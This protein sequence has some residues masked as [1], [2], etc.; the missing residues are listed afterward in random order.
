MKRKFVKVQMN[1]KKFMFLLDTGSDVTLINEQ[2]WR[3][4]DRPTLLKTEKITHDFTGNKQKFEGECYT[5]VTFIGKAIKLIRF[6]MNR[7]VNLF[8]MVL[9]ESFNLLNRPINSLCYSVSANSNIVEKLLKELMIKFP[10]IFSE[11]LGR[12]TKAKA[13]FKIKEN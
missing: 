6:V 13:I 12:Y 5:N 9:I 8:S 2:T 4:I 1:N 10:G 11:G 7:N 3:K